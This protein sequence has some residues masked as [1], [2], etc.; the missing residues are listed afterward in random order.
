LIIIIKVTKSDNIQED[1]N[2]QENDNDQITEVSNNDQG[3]TSTSEKYFKN[4]SQIQEI[5]DN[6]N[7]SVQNEVSD[8]HQQS[9]DDDLKSALTSLLSKKKYKD[10]DLEH[11]LKSLLFSNKRNCD[12]NKVDL[13]S[14]DRSLLNKKDPFYLDLSSF[15]PTNEELYDLN[16]EK[17]T[18]LSKNS[19]T[20]SYN[21]NHPQRIGYDYQAQSSQSR[22]HQKIISDRAKL[23]KSLNSQRIINEQLSQFNNSQE[24]IDDRTQ[25]SQSSNYQE[26]I[27][28]RTQSS[29]SRRRHQEDNRTWYKNQHCRQLS[30][31]SIS[32]SSP[33]SNKEIIGVNF[34]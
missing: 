29:Q 25:S 19:I 23:N 32:T 3:Q 28:D 31:E 30:L 5:T 20:K 22:N 27:D 34:I 33:V 14:T 7:A 12:Q 11:A 9:D 10:G 18:C 17:N 15:T 24:I 4:V 26:I 8:I 6:N 16:T 21:S 13:D 1:N 2:I